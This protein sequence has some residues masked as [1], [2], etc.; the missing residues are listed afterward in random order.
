MWLVIVVV[1]IV[2]WLLLFVVLLDW[3]WFC[4]WIGFEVCD[5]FL[6]DFVFD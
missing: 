2:M 3:F 1:V 4:V 5:Y 6:W